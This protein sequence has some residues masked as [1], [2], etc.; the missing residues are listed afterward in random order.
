MSGDDALRDLRYFC[1]WRH[2]SEEPTCLPVDCRKLLPNSDETTVYLFD[3]KGERVKQLANAYG[4]AEV[5]VIRNS[6]IVFHSGA[7]S[8]KLHAQL[9]F[10]T[11]P[12][13]LQKRVEDIYYYLHYDLHLLE[14]IGPQLPQLAVFDTTTFES[15][16]TPSSKRTS[17]LSRQLVRLRAMHA[18]LLSMPAPASV[19]FADTSPQAPQVIYEA[20][21]EDSNEVHYVN[22]AQETESDTRLA[23]P[24]VDLNNIAGDVILVKIGETRDGQGIKSIIPLCEAPADD[25]NF[26][27]P[28]SKRIRLVDA[29]AVP[30]DYA[31]RLTHLSNLSPPLSEHGRIALPNL[32]DTNDLSDWPPPD[33]VQDLICR[34]QYPDHGNINT[35]LAC[36]PADFRFTRCALKF[37]EL[38]NANTRNSTIVPYFNH[39]W[40]QDHVGHVI[41]IDKGTPHHRELTVLYLSESHVKLL[42][43]DMSSVRTG[44]KVLY[45][46][47]NVAVFLRE[48]L[49][50]K[51]GKVKVQHMNYPTYSTDS[52]S[53][54]A[55]T[56]ENYAYFCSDLILTKMLV[57]KI[58][59]G[60][61]DENVQGKLR[62]CF[63]T[64]DPFWFCRTTLM[65]NSANIAPRRYKE[66]ILYFAPSTF[67]IDGN[68][69]HIHLLSGL[70]NVTLP[71]NRLFR[72]DAGHLFLNYT[73]GEVQNWT[74]VEH[75]GSDYVNFRSRTRGCGKMEYPPFQFYLRTRTF[76]NADSSRFQSSIVLD[77]NLTTRTVPKPN[78]GE[79][80][81]SVKA[82]RTP[83]NKV[84]MTISRATDHTHLVEHDEITALVEATDEGIKN[85]KLDPPS[86]GTGDLTD[87]ALKWLK[88]KMM[89]PKTLGLVVTTKNDDGSDEDKV[90]AFAKRNLVAP[91][92]RVDNSPMQVVEISDDHG[93][94][95][96]AI[97]TR[98]IEDFKWSTPINVLQL[99][100]FWTRDEE[101]ALTSSHGFAVDDALSSCGLKPFKAKSYSTAIH[102]AL[103]R[104]AVSRGRDI[105]CH[106]SPESVPIYQLKRYD[107]YPFLT[108]RGNPVTLYATSTA[109]CISASDDARTAVRVPL[110]A[111]A[112][113]VETV[114]LYD[115][116]A[117]LRMGTGDMR[118]VTLANPKFINNVS[119]SP[120][121]D[122]GLDPRVVDN[123][124][125]PYRSYWSCETS[126]FI[127]TRE[128]LV[129]RIAETGHAAADITQVSVCIDKDEVGGRRHFVTVGWND[130]HDRG[131]EMGVIGQTDVGRKLT[132]RDGA[133]E[134]DDYPRVA[135][136]RSVPVRDFSNAEI[137][138]TT[139]RRVEI[140]LP[141]DD[142][143]SGD[144]SE[145]DSSG[146]DDGLYIKKQ[147][148]RWTI[149][150]PSHTRCAQ[151]RSTD[152]MR[153]ALAVMVT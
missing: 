107:D 20:T 130:R 94:C 58:A 125:A 76:V 63:N 80:L 120:Q 122:N 141:D 6:S 124:P 144:D 151:T 147:G 99:L 28:L 56:D 73:F 3:E 45:D 114:F 38:R 60:F 13:Q 153:K 93:I 61:A 86:T 59:N 66:Q 146:E 53:Q 148:G 79:K 14:E 17:S 132:I 121:V 44:K 119:S 32:V 9:L 96:I 4:F 106:Y 70:D 133:L 62:R 115:G 48:P 40:L 138:S 51:N 78:L 102:I 129:L 95:A 34:A 5:C 71:N 1:T 22:I 118:D 47:Y 150:N 113:R 50:T 127:S 97:V 31:K 29:N 126:D 52:W 139:R 64:D 77:G 100:L 135:F 128:H 54:H 33:H 91:K 98:T 8:S 105:L 15:N 101:T 37:D 143:S 88:T 72:A 84:R 110:Q 7:A 68:S 42:R 82:D 83:G 92:R 30:E 137:L 46:E 36:V 35:K 140:Q 149:P 89:S 81:F 117:R 11:L 43:K 116:Y 10:R 75:E 131:E 65:T 18:Q 49:P 55:C 136:W 109:Y 19:S 123:R 57:D 67:D 142:N 87:D 41:R 21:Q 103:S 85:V 27:A 145:E 39:L 26:T 16:G 134:I 112:V 74:E 12:L 2:L 152:R 23:S 69:A 111:K 108:E 90:F 24:Y 25:T 104:L